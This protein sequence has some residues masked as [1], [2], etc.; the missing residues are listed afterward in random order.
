MSEVNSSTIDNHL[1]KQMVQAV[2]EAVDPSQVILFGSQARGTAK[3]KSDV[4]FL[5]VETESFGASRSRRKEAAKVWRALAKFGIPTDVL[6][7]S[8]DEIAEWSQSP[9]HVIA[10]ALEE[11]KIVYERPEVMTF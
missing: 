8:V 9:N 7:Y 1:L 3:P 4:D 6:M 2:V 5:V 10:R 11:G